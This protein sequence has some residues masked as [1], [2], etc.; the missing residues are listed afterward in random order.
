MNLC[1]IDN[2]YT[3]APLFAKPS[4]NND[5]YRHS[6]EPRKHLR[7]T[8]NGRNPLTIVLKLS[9]LDVRRSPDYGLVPCS[10]SSVANFEHAIA[11]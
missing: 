10:S 9:I 1:R 3:S 7:W 11:D 5:T 8:V 6:Q 4:R 2:H